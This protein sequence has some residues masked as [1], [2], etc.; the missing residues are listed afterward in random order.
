M[1]EIWRSDIA[2]ARHRYLADEYY[3][4]NKDINTLHWYPQKVSQLSDH[5]LTLAAA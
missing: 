4:C 5:I 1:G 2:T 3:R